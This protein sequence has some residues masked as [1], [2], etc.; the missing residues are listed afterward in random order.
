MTRGTPPPAKPAAPRIAA[1]LMDRQP[2]AVTPETRVGEVARL[3]V[4][5]RV[6]GVPVVAPSGE[7]IGL[8][9]EA[10][11]VTRHAHV[12]FPTYLSLFGMAIPLSTRRGQRELD[13]ETRRIVART[14]AEIM[15]EDFQEHAVEEVTPLEDVA[16][17]LARTGTD[18]LVVLRGDRLAGLITR[19]ALVRLVAVEEASEGPGE[20]ETSS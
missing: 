4:E 13:E 19:T 3:I 12:H 16:A 17:R 10:D 7:V 9:T 1:D 5:R 20:E 15:K 11:L 14:A 18:P 8:I 2:A 6:S